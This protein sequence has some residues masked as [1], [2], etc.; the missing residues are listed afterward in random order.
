MLGRGHKMFQELQ[1]LLKEA[2]GM[3]MLEAGILFVGVM[4]I[5]AF[6]AFVLL[7]AGLIL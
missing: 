4:L 1:R 7:S 2:T 5:I 3:S 6:I